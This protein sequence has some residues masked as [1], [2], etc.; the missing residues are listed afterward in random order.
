LLITSLRQFANQQFRLAFA[1][2]IAG[3]EVDVTNFHVIRFARMAGSNGGPLRRAP[4]AGSCGPPE[5]R[6]RDLGFLTFEP[7][8]NRGRG[9]V[10]PDVNAG[11]RHV[12]YAVKHHQYA[13]R[14]HRQA[15][16]SQDDRYGNQ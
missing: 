4:T 8:H 7:C 16:R 11:P 3:G 6:Q 10:T 9:A 13:D 2:A 15:D 1:A 12:E 5:L 14:F